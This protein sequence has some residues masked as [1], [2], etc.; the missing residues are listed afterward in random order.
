LIKHKVNENAGDRNIQP[1]RHRPFSDP[2]MF[3]PATLKY[4]HEGKNDER[5]GNEGE[6]N[7]AGQ[8]WE[9]NGRQPPA[10]A[11]RFFTNLGMIG[12]VTSEKQG[13]GNDRCDHA[14]DVALPKIPANKVPAG[15]NENRAD[16]VQRGV[17]GGEIGG[18]K[19]VEG[20]KG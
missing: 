3:V 7:V 13:R 6:Q 12:E 19:H 17:D 9:V 10:V 8:Y 20:L 14:G 15:R 1:N 11:G 5:E 18:G 16:G 2:T 4:R